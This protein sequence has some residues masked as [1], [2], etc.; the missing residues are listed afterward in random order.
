ELVSLMEEVEVLLQGFPRLMGE[1]GQPGYLVITLAQLDQPIKS[2]QT[3][4][5]SQREALDR[6]WQSGHK[7][8][9]EHLGFLR[10]EIR[11]MRK[12]GPGD[13]LLR[14]TRS[15][16]NDH[17]GALLLLLGLLALNIAIW[18]TAFVHN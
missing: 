12:R 9:K 18:R 16:L 1:A 7:L 13:R 10:E 11:A 4:S 17:P 6:D 15:F 3:L 8:L 2:F 5:P 14:A